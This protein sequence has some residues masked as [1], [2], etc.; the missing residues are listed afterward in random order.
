MGKRGLVKGRTPGFQE[1]EQALK[2]CEASSFHL[3]ETKPTDNSSVCSCSRFGPPGRERLLTPRRLSLLTSSPPSHV[4]ESAPRAESDSSRRLPPAAP[5]VSEEGAV[6]LPPPP[7]I[8]ANNFAYLEPPPDDL[9][10]GE[11]LSASSDASM[12]GNLSRGQGVQRRVKERDRGGGDT[13]IPKQS[14]P[15]A[16]FAALPFTL[17]SRINYFQ[18]F[19]SSPP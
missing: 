2:M 16:Q 3:C 19:Y 13:L 8:L 7:H 11:P 6:L 4:A 1:F 12:G 17:N 9:P 10:D 14:L 18:L 15:W 5:A